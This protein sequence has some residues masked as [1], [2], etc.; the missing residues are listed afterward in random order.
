MAIVK[1][2]AASASA[3]RF[4][5]F[6]S[7]DYSPQEVYNK[8]S[9]AEPL[10]DRLNAGSCGKLEVYGVTD[11][12]QTLICKEDLGT[13]GIDLLPREFHLHRL[14]LELGCESIPKLHEDSNESRLVMPLINCGATLQDYLLEVACGSLPEEVGV[15]IL[16]AV[17]IA[18][19]DFYSYGVIHGDLHTRNI[20]IVCQGGGWRAYII[21]LGLSAYPDWQMYRRQLEAD[22]HDPKEWYWHMVFDVQYPEIEEDVN[23]I[24]KFIKGDFAEA[25]ESPPLRAALD[26]LEET[27]LSFS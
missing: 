12:G 4:V 9:R 15:D 14:L 3:S 11:E 24:F 19:E 17:R 8:V 25:F 21:D 20:L 23:R 10:D 1:F 16:E 5:V 6:P 26:Y 13:M 2:S 22:Y 18:L 27:M 7:G